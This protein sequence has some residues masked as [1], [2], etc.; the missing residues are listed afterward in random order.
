V[1][2]PEIIIVVEGFTVLRRIENRQS[3]HRFLLDAESPGCQAIVRRRK[4]FAKP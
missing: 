4:P 2:S 1:M 3:M